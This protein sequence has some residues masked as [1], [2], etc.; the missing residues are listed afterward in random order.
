MAQIAELIRAIAY[1][2]GTRINA[3]ANAD[4]RRHEEISVNP[5]KIRDIRVQFR[6]TG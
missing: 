5:P 4:F 6:P 3:N 1:K 2:N